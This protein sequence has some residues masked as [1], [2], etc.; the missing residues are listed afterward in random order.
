[1]LPWIDGCAPRRFREVNLSA[2]VLVQDDKPGRGTGC[3]RGDT[4]PCRL[5]GCG[6]FQ[7]HNAA[8]LID[9]EDVEKLQ[10]T[11]LSARRARGGELFEGE[12]NG[13]GVESAG[14]QID[15]RASVR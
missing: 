12:T 8:M 6:R 11:L 2:G 14:H 1:M 15:V 13:C 9:T 5:Q 7:P 3:Q 4:F 10:H